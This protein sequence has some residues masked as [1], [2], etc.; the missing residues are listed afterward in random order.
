MKNSIYVL[1]F[2]LIVGSI[3]KKGVFEYCDNDVCFNFQITQNIVIFVF[4]DENEIIEQHLI[5]INDSVYLENS[6]KKMLFYVK[7][8][9]YKDSDSLIKIKKKNMNFYYPFGNIVTNYNLRRN[10]IEL[11]RRG[12]ELLSND[13]F[14]TKVKT[15][16]AK[17]TIVY[18]NGILEKK[19]TLLKK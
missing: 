14:I 13:K 16:G 9:G 5:E 10:E 3:N 1:L 11:D 17:I 12:N 8:N 19:Y 2:F 18:Y 4:K 6:S 15:S 7:R